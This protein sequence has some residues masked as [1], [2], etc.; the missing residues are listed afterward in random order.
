M[1]RSGSDDAIKENGGV[2]FTSLISLLQSYLFKIVNLL[3]NLVGINWLLGCHVMSEDFDYQE[4]STKRCKPDDETEK[5]ALENEDFGLY[6][7]PVDD[8]R[9][10]AISDFQN[11][12]WNLKPDLNFVEKNTLQ[13]VSFDEEG[14]SIRNL[15]VTIDETEKE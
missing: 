4:N 6:K 14:D 11:R 13:V 15:K 1:V 5:R 9:A 2:T 7:K 10:K 8:D 12:L 3:V